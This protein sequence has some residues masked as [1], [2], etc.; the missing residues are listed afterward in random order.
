MVD[1]IRSRWIEVSL[2]VLTI[3]FSVA[4]SYAAS[5]RMVTIVDERSKENSRRV[6]SLESRTPDKEDLVLL[7]AA[8]DDLKRRLDSLPPGWLVDRVE[9]ID[10]RV[11]DLERTK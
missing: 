6:N 7:R 8:I 5:V 11:R 3:L 10:A 1:E 2:L 9:I 4:G